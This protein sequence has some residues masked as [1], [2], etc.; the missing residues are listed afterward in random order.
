[1]IFGGE[2]MPAKRGQAVL[3]LRAMSGGWCLDRWQVAGRGV[4]CAQIHP[5]HLTHVQTKVCQV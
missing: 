1:M 4:A 3:G 5:C 2:V